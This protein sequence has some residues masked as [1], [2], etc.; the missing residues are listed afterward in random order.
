MNRC[1]RLCYQRQLIYAGL[2]DFNPNAVF[3]NYMGGADGE[4][5]SEWQQAVV[6]FLDQGVGCGVLTATNWDDMFSPEEPIDIEGV[7][8]GSCRHEKFH[9]DRDIVWNALYFYGTKALI[10]ELD[11][12][13]LNS[14]E[15]MGFPENIGFLKEIQKKFNMD[16]SL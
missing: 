13:C 3:S 14:W 6:T 8:L 9:I 10:E 4:R 7:L 15:A 2:D 12:F 16:F 1:L 11:R 5:S